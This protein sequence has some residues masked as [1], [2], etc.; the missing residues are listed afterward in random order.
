METTVWLDNAIFLDHLALGPTQWVRCKIGI[1]HFCPKN[2]HYWSRDVNY[3]RFFG[4]V[5]TFGPSLAEPG[6]SKTGLKLILGEG[7]SLE[8][9][10]STSFPSKTAFPDPP[11]APRTPQT[12]PGEV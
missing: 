2:G 3:P 11:R 12:P 4:H 6:L 1:A 5:L 7:G 9:I 8:V 10:E